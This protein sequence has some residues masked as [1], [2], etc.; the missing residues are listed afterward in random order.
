MKGKMIHTDQAPQ[1]VGPYS[2]GV[3]FGDWLYV[4]GQIPIDPT[5][6]E[7]LLGDIEHQ[8][9][10]VLKN[11]QAIVTAAGLKLTDVA[12][13][14]IYLTQMEAFPKV[15]EVYAKFFDVFLPAR[16]CVGVASLPKG[17]GVEMDAVVYAGDKETA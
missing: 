8:A 1:A 6:N 3:K 15:N 9:E 10:Q 4:S 14:N 16:A 13:V 2:Q 11:L 17:V 5:T 7:L 12:K